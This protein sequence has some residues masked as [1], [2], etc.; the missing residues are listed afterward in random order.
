M[1]EPHNQNWG[2]RLPS[3][4]IYRPSKK[5]CG[6][7]CEL[8]LNGAIPL[9]NGPSPQ[10]L[11]ATLRGIAQISWTAPFMNQKTQSRFE[12]ESTKFIFGFKTILPQHI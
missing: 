2:G 12:G 3:L 10:K 9:S 8:Q 6:I 5:E 11:D 4:P 7:R 1:C